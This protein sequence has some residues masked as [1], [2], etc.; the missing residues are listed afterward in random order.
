MPP[1]TDETA[2][3]AEQTVTA[4]GTDYSVSLTYTA[5]ANIPEGSVFELSEVPEGGTVTIVPIVL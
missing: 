3:P 5:D 1:S 2:A 4:S